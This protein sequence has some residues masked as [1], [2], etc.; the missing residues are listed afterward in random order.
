MVTILQ[1]F[2]GQVEILLIGI[3]L[4]CFRH[5]IIGDKTKIAE[6][7]P[8][9]FCNGYF[10]AYLIVMW[11]GFFTWLTWYIQK[12]RW[13]IWSL[14]FGHNPILGWAALG[15]VIISNV[16]MIVMDRYYYSKD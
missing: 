10:L 15:V 16:I 6:L 13:G 11:F 1:A 7:F 12:P 5:I 8:D 14:L 2:L 3:T 9:Y 4:L